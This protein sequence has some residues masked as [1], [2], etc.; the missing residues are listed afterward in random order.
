V[1][2]IGVGVTAATSG[3]VAVGVAVRAEVGGE[4]ACAAGGVASEVG[5]EVACAGD[6][7]ADAGG[8]AA[9]RDPPVT[10]AAGA[11]AETTASG[12]G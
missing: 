12:R 4:V 9:G 8:L 5:G 7:V 1:A 2:A 10:A 3:V 6:G 11:E